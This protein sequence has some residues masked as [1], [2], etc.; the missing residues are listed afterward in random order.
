MIDLSI[1]KSKKNNYNKNKC[2]NIEHNSL[3]SKLKAWLFQ[4]LKMKF[5]KKQ[6]KSPKNNKSMSN[7]NFNKLL[8]ISNGR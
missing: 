6:K 5:N 7:N 8:N 3:E 4:Q 2:N 1:L